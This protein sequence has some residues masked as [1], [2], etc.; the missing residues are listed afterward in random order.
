MAGMR[1][2]AVDDCDRKHFARGYCS[3][4]YGFLVRNGDPTA[5]KRE[6]GRTV[7]SIDG[8]DERHSARGLCALHYLRW[9]KAG[10]PGEAERRIA[11]RGEG[12]HQH[13]AGYVYVTLSKDDPLWVMTNDRG[14]V[15]EH[16]VVMARS[17]G[18]PL[19]DFENVHHLNG[20]K[21]DNRL[22]NLEL[23]TVPPTCGQRPEDL[24]RW[25]VEN[26]P[27]VIEAVMR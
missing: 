9:S 11:K 6:Y 27:E 4:H 20:D 16:R 5:R 3:S 8:C 14:R 23:W 17:I 24:A 19:R 13:P 25:V 15:M 21:A 12:R 1:L 10:D 26:Y 2:C 7:C 18:R 22:E